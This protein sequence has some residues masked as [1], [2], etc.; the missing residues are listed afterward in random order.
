MTLAATQHDG[1]MSS[2]P[3]PP[4]S[5]AANAAAWLLG[6]LT[7]VRFLTI[8][9]LSVRRP[10]RPH[11]LGPAEAFFP[12][13][14][15]LIGALLVG[16]DWLLSSIASGLVVDVLLVAAVAAVT[17]ALHLDGVVDTFDGVFAPGGPARRL[18]IMRDPRAGSFGVI[19]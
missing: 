14:G 13:A 2:Y 3:R 11:E 15:L 18:E 19:A 12:F 7:A 5:A 6:P 4:V 9:P 8:L 10:T 16:I 1:L 17:G